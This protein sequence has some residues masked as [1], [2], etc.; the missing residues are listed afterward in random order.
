MKKIYYILITSIVFISCEALLFEEDL[1]DRSVIALAPLHNSVVESVNV[2]FNWSAVEDANNYQFQIAIPD[3]VSASQILIDSILPGTSYNLILEPN[4]YQW[5]VRALNEH[6]ET[7]YTTVSFSVQPETFNEDITDEIITLIAPSDGSLLDSNPMTFSW[8][9]VP[10]TESYI[11]QIA[12]PDFEN[13]TQIV[14]DESVFDTSWQQS[15][16]DGS[17]QWRIKAKNSS[18]ETSF[19]AGSFS[20]EL[21]PIEEDISQEIVTLIA[22]SEGSVLDTNPITFSWENVSFAENYV[23]QIATPDFDNPTQVVVDMSLTE[24]TSEQTIVNGNY[25]WRVKAVNS[26]S[27]T[28]YATASFSVL[29]DDSN[30]ISNETVNLIAPSNGVD[31]TD[32]NITFTWN[33]VPF[34]DDYVLQIATPDFINPLQ[35]VVDETL[36]N[37]SSSQTLNDGSYQWRVKARNSSSETNYSTNSFTV[38]TGINFSDRIVVIISP[39]DNFISNQP[40]LNIQ[41]EPVEDATLY[42]IQILDAATNSLVDE[43]TTT[44][45]STPFTFPEGELIWQ[46]RAETSSESTGYTAQNITIDSVAPNTPILLTPLDTEILTSTLVN[47]TYSRE[48]I[49]GTAES[50]QI[51]IY[52]DP[53]LTIL[54]LQQEVSGGTFNTTL[55]NNQTYYWKMKAFDL[56]GNQSSDSSVFSFTINE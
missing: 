16:E 37:T 54:V 43:Q 38:S 19:F 12:T 25:Q 52:E 15:L 40:T 32:N 20:V 39:P 35:V 33:E 30:D 53:A 9:E 56:A 45:T 17:Y 26:S 31:L 28:L 7:L 5:R 13:A 49:E 36:A 10:F 41:W 34:A 47:F 18:S 50:D 55:T 48:A 8:Q 42:R 44:L 3:F 27:E 1:S 51:S 23:L 2:S 29:V 46:V 6:S 11:L 24:T 14:V 21:A 4:S 22:P